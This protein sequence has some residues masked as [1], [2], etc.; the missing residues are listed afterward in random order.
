VSTLRSLYTW[1]IVVI[2]NP[3]REVDRDGVSLLFLSF[4]LKMFR[5]ELLN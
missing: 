2:N 4:E 3:E 5:V 1:K